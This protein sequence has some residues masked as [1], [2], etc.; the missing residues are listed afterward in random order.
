[1]DSEYSKF[2]DTFDLNVCGDSIV[3]QLLSFWTLSIVLFQCLPSRKMAINRSNSVKHYIILNQNLPFF[4]RCIHL[5]RPSNFAISVSN[6]LI[7][8]RQNIKI[9]KSKLYTRMHEGLRHAIVLL[10]EALCYQPE[11]RGFK[12]Q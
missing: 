6:T 8:Q 1:M 12:S 9:T 10:V 5:V 4:S 7:T 11:G 2:G 3:I